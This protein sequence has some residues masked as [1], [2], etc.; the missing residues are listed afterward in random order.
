M[1]SIKQNAILNIVYTITNILF[2]LVTFPYVS[3][4]LSAEGLGKVSLFTS[5]AN[6]AIMFAALGISTYGIRAT[7]KVRN[8]KKQLSQIVFELVVINLVAT[9]VVIGLLA[10]ISLYVPKLNREPELLIINAVLIFSSALGFNWLYS[11]LEQYSF[12]TIRSLF[13]KIIA[14][15]FTFA[16]VK[17]RDDYIIYAGITAFSSVGS[18]IINFIYAR[19]FILFPQISKLKF[20]RH[21]KPMIYLFASILAVSIYTNLDTIMLGFIRDDTEVGLYTIAVKVKWLLLNVINAISAVLLPRLSFYASEKKMDEFNNILKKSIS[22]IF[23]IALP[24]TLF[25]IVEAKETILIIGGKDY[26]GAVYCMQIT[27][28]ILLISSISNITGNQ[29][30]IPMGYDSYFMRAVILGAGVDVCL[31]I[32]LMPN[33]GCMGAAVA[34]L[35]AEAVQLF[36]QYLYSREYLVKNINSATLFKILKSAF[37]AIAIVCILKKYIIWNLI[38]NMFVLTVIYFGIYYLLLLL[39]REPLIKEYTFDILKK[40][41][42]K[43]R[44]NSI[45]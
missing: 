35:V 6:Y 40:I 18:Y 15:I 44:T 31:N 16:L 45:D 14:L 19:K 27:M 42:L 25:F 33:I 36:M 41:N 5:I 29:I 2:P 24:L 10:I 38:G 4:V 11:G 9:L 23:M 3:R 28:P 30:L 1:K 43:K 26:L 8:D 37:G 17:N 13:F 39:F 22:T 20:K 21:F 34:T 7:A 12:I 32:I